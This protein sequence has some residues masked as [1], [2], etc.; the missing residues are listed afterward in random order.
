MFH[1]GGKYWD[2]WNDRLH[3]LLTESQVM[4]GPMAGSWD[5]KGSIPDRWGPHAGRIY[6]TTMNLLSLEVAYRHL[7]I[8]ED[9]AK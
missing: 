7:P 3:P 9:T 6:V 2:T 8:Y 5:P 4:T 1:M